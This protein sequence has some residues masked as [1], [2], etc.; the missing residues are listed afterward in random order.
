[1]AFSPSEGDR[2]TITSR[3][4]MPRSYEMP[5]PLANSSFRIV[6]A[7]NPPRHANLTGRTLEIV[8][9]ARRA[10]GRAPRD[11]DPPASRRMDVILAVE[12]L[13]RPAGDSSTITGSYPPH[14][15]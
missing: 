13:A 3:R 11:D 4:T 15:E 8:L 2:Q 10:D 12:V 9:L 5:P 1:M 7:A 14:G 6:R